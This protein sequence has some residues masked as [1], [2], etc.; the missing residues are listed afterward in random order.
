MEKLFAVEVIFWQGFI[1]TFFSTDLRRH[2]IKSMACQE[3]AACGEE[4]ERVCVC[5]C[6]DNAAVLA[7]VFLGLSTPLYF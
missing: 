3:Q 1:Y 5:I 7:V 6:Q 2:L 4:G